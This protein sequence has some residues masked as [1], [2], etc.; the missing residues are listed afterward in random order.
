MYLNKTKTQVITED[1]LFA[2][3]IFD[4]NDGIEL[5]YY[6]SETAISNPNFINFS[7]LYISPE[8]ARQGEELILAEE[9]RRAKAFQTAT[10]EEL[11]QEFLTEK[12]VTTSSNGKVVDFLEYR[13]RMEEKGPRR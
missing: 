12:E 6:D 2:D 8:A 4:E 7:Y 11:L 10:E 1:G 13:K 3:I 5:S 9:E